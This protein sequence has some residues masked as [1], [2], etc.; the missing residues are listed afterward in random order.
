MRLYRVGE[1][2]LVLPIRVP[3]KRV[4]CVSLLVPV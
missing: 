1:S 3:I 2:N 4:H